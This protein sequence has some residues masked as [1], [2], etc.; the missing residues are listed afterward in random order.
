MRQEVEARAL[1]RAASPEYTGA[2]VFGTTVSPQQT[3]IASVEVDNATATLSRAATSPLSTPPSS[4]FF[5]RLDD[6]DNDDG[7][8]EGGE[9][10]E[11]VSQQPE[12]S[13]PTTS[14][15]RRPDGN[16]EGLRG[17]NDRVIMFPNHP[18]PAFPMPA[19][20]RTNTEYILDHYP[21][22]L[23]RPEVMNLF[24]HPPGQRFGGYRNKYLIDRLL[25]H[26]LRIDRDNASR[27]QRRRTVT[28]WI[29]RQKQVAYRARAAGKL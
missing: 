19:V 27:N 26:T 18:D 1:L 10:E 21:R 8:E 7:D 9:E 11:N 20:H 14:T 4:P 5:N 29:S 17:Q 23:T 28:R 16:S 2:Q 13:V 24:C 3:E 22:H 25:R 6:D 15:E 12:S